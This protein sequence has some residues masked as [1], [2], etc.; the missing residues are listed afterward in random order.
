MWLEI[1]LAFITS[2]LLRRWYL[3][4]EKTPLGPGGEVIRPYSSIP[5]PVQLPLLGT[6]LQL[7]IGGYLGKLHIW[8]YDR[9]T[10]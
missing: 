3:G 7:M 8:M 9:A 6:S 1:L 4:R 10:R 2:L 5:G